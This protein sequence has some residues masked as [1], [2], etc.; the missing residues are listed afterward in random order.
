MRA[1]FLVPLVVLAGCLGANDEGE[2]D[3]DSTPALPSEVAVE[4]IR[5]DTEMGPL[6]VML[7]PEAAPHT[8]KLM[9][10]YVNESYYDDREFLRTIPGFVIQI[11]DRFGGETEDDRRVPLESHLDYDFSAGAVGVA[12]GADNYTGGPEIF[13]MD[14]PASHLNGNYTLWGQLV[15]GQDVVHRIAR[16]PAIDQGEAPPQAQDAL[17]LTPVG[18]LFYDRTAAKP[19]KVTGTSFVTVTLP[20]EEAAKYPLRTAKSFRDDRFRSQLEWPAD[21]A[22]GRETDFSWYVRGYG[23]NVPPAAS[24]VGI[25]IA[26]ET[27]DVTG[28][29]TPGIYHFAWTPPSA[30]NHTATLLVGGSEFHSLRI[31]V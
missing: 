28:E 12:R 25:V 5:F 20:A 30:G 24:E 15:E 14:F 10:T 17:G 19:V 29:A 27:F 2:D 4:A 31:V 11:A 16:L 23:D 22:V 7:Y 8:V 18:G 1:V 3:P 26:N 9:R 6:V 21:I 13:F